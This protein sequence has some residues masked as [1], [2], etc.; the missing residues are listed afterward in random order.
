MNYCLYGVLCGEYSCTVSVG[1]CADVHGRCVARGRAGQC[2]AHI[3][4]TNIY[5]QVFAIYDEVLFVVVVVV[6]KVLS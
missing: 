2:H 3:L 1:L 5:H 6:C 4:R